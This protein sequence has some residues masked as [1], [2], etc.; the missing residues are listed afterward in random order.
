LLV[1][2]LWIIAGFRKQEIR[3]SPLVSPPL[4][5]VADYQEI[6]ERAISDLP[7][8]TPQ[9]RQALYARAKSA[10]VTQLRAQE[11]TAAEIEREQRELE[12][13]IRTVE[14]RKH[15]RTRGA[16]RRDPLFATK[17]STV[18]LVVSVFFFPRLWLIDVTCMSLWWVAR[19]PQL[20]KAEE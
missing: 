7:G 20:G 8:N 5:S 16:Q 11:V 2:V 4:R 19:L 17:S 13:A 6:L 1:I 3:K 18:L 10:L 12:A 9:A 15:P 14:A